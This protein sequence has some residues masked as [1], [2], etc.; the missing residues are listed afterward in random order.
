[1]NE[2]KNNPCDAGGTGDPTP[3]S[4]IPVDVVYTYVD[5]DS[6]HA[7]KRMRYRSVSENA[8]R[9]MNDDNARYCNVGEIR[10]GVRSVLK[11]MPWVRQIL[12]VTDSQRPP[13][14][15]HLLDS[16]RVRIVDHREF[17]PKPYLPTFNSMTIESLLHR[18]DGL[19]E[20]YLYEND[21]F[22]HFSAVPESALFNVRDNGHAELTLNAD[23][24]AKRRVMTW[25]AQFLPSPWAALL[26]NP[27]T[28]AIAN[29]FRLLRQGPCR[30]AWHEIIVPKHVTHVY[31]KDTARR[32]D[33]EFATRLDA[34]RS[35]RFRTPDQF[36]YSTLA[37][38]VER[39]WHPLDRLRTTIR[40]GHPDEIRMFDFTALF[41]CRQ[42][43]WKQVA[44]SRAMFACL[45]NIPQ[46]DR[47]IFEDTMRAKGLGV[48]DDE[49]DETE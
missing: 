8:Q 10:Y 32:I 41:A 33:D 29:A 49:L 23:Y 24:A 20:I 40:A 42:K 38:S 5:G 2:R 25:T 4:P 3:W 48:P 13:V 12:V 17:I 22:I 26:A 36:S 15:S 16:G 43:L 1:M 34:N 6:A 21:D 45:N 27:H 9:A 39:M 14:D 35:L 30:L 46:A 44:S 47:S 18:I 31:R 11:H 7:E 28:A 19:S 37:Y